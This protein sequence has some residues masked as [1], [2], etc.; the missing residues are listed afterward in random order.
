MFSEYSLAGLTRAIGEEFQTIDKEDLMNTQ[1][2]FFSHPQHVGLLAAFR[3][4]LGELR[5]E[6]QQAKLQRQ[7]A[8]RIAHELSG[9]TDRELADLRHSR[10]DI[11][12][13]A[14]GS[15]GRA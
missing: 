12:D 2:A 3:I 9:Y 14:R 5:L 6:W 10:A 4:K 8:A 1:P 7:E 15:F 13:V 11:P